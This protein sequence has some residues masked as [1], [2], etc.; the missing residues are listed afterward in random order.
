M[1]YDLVG[2]G[3]TNLFWTPTPLSPNPHFGPRPSPPPDSSA[4]SVS[5]GRRGIRSTYAGRDQY[6]YWT[7]VIA[8]DGTGY[9]VAA[10]AMAAPDIVKQYTLWPY[11]TSCSRIRYGSTG[12]RVAV[13]AMAVP[14]N[15]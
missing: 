4:R 7:S 10:Y 9:H 1:A 2:T 8:C 13:Y 6:Q 12:Q 5:T 3:K 11:R 15:A 14:D